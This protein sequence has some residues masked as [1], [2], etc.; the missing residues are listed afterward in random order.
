MSV[1]LHHYYLNKQEPHK[2]CLL[3]L[4]SILLEQDKNIT[5]TQKWGMPCFCYKNK[6][7]C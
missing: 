3:A 7:F 1:E 6:M 5:E 2:R 4:R